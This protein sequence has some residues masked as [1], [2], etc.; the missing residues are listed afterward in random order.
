MI[1]NKN[2]ENFLDVCEVHKQYVGLGNPNS[3]ILFIGKEPGISSEAES[4]HGTAQSWKKK[5]PYWN[6]YTPKEE[7]LK[8]KN[9]TWQKYQKL[10][11][12]IFEGLNTEKFTKED[13]EITFVEHVFTTELN[14]I[15]ASTSN[16]AKKNADFKPNLKKRKETFWKDDFINQFQIVIIFALDRKYIETYEGEVRDLFGV[17]YSPKNKAEIEYSKKHK[18]WVYKSKD[19]SKN[20]FPKLLIHTRQLTNGASNDLIEKIGDEI[21]SFVKKEKIQLFN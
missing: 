4:V 16:E 1:F 19:D 9:H 21:I 6:R 8:N 15:H 3:K 18:L 10:Y 7:K 12:H 2:F 17:E 20:I 5:T 14:N 11:E 13:H